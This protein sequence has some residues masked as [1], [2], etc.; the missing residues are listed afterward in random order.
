MSLFLSIRNHSSEITEI[1]GKL[2]P[3]YND[4]QFSVFTADRHGNLQNHS[5]VSPDAPGEA[6]RP[7]NHLDEVSIIRE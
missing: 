1:V 2:L 7:P 6:Q 5:K 4:L 3:V